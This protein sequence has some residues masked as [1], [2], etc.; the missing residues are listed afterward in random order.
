VENALDNLIERIYRKPKASLTSAPKNQSSRSFS[1][2]IGACF[3]NLSLYIAFL[4][5]KPTVP[6]LHVYIFKD[7]CNLHIFNQKKPD[8][9]ILHNFLNI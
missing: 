6:A 9:H 7:E 3:S 2:N 4:K 5:E 1:Q 8:F